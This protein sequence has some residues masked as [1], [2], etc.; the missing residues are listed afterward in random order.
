[1]Y[2]CIS[3][4]ILHWLF[5]LLFHKCV[6][7]ALRA[8]LYGSNII[9]VIVILSTSVVLRV[10]VFWTSVFSQLTS[11]KPAFTQYL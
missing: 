2:I 1:M 3:L 6:F 8:N 7:C 9:V 4:V 11:H 5:V 10:L